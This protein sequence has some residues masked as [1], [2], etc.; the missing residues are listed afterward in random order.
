M[1]EK[2]QHLSVSGYNLHGSSYS[3][4]LAHGGTTPG[5]RGSNEF[6]CELKYNT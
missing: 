3:I 1:D 6:I 5:Y 4:N 2:T